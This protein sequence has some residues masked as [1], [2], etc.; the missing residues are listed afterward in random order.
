MLIS[1]VCLWL[2]CSRGKGVLP[3]LTR[4][5]I[6]WNLELTAITELLSIAGALRLPGVA[7]FWV[8]SDLWLLT[9]T[10]RAVRH[11]EVH[12]PDTHTLQELSPRSHSVGCWLLAAVSAVMVF[13]ALF[14]VTYNWDS[15]T[16]HLPRICQWAQNGTVDHYSTHCVRQISS[17][18]LAEYVML[19]IYLLTGKSDVLINLV[20]CISAI[21]CAVYSW[22]IARKL[23][24]S[25]AFSRLAAIMT[26]S[27]PILFAEAFTAEADIYS[28]L[29][30]MLFA[31]LLLDFVTAQSLHF[32]QKTGRDVLYLGITVSLGYLAKPSVGIAML[33]LVAWMGITRLVKRD[34]LLDLVRLGLLAVPAVVIPMIPT[35]LRNL[36]SFHSLQSSSVSDELMVGTMQPR[37][38]LANLLKHIFGNLQNG[39]IPGS[40]AL[41]NRIVAN[42][43]WLLQLNMDDDAISLSG[44]TFGNGDYFKFGNDDA[45]NP[46]FMLLLL[47]GVGW[48]LVRVIYLAIRR[49]KTGER[50]F[51]L[52]RQYLPICFVAFCAMGCTLRW[53]YWGARLLMPFMVLCVPGIAAEA[54]DFGTAV[55]KNGKKILLGLLW[56]LCL[57]DLSVMITTF[58][59]KKLFATRPEGYFNAEH[60]IYS[61]E[62]YG[63]A[64]D[65]ILENGWRNVGLYTANDTYEY[66]IWAMLKSEDPVIRHVFPVTDPYDPPFTPDVIFSVDRDLS[67]GGFDRD[68]VWYSVIWQQ[69]NVSLLR[70]E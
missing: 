6:L 31:Y 69:G 7:L 35:S 52:A 36:H 23:G 5:L 1:F 59:A 18:V 60:C 30:V 66:P 15:M 25:T 8:V 20:Q 4:A 44:A 9:L 67:D 45:T 33:V 50:V 32:T 14:T 42:F 49:K 27:I 11:G 39:Y 12:L 62:D 2:L 54:E 53:Q 47:A 19:H 56:A 10:V 64:C 40:A 24:V 57:L 61:A 29:W 51:T 13:F 65:Y 43:G 16:Y 63:A 17:P 22:G 38:L 28:S 3:G 70:A 55:L 34:K 58:H 68:G 46:I 21:L 37:F 41:V 48:W 26:L